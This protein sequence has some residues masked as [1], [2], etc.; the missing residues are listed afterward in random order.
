MC[1]LPA[2]KLDCE[3]ADPSSGTLNQDTLTSLQSPMVKDSLPGGC[4]THRHSSRLVKIQRL[5][6]E[7][8]L[9]HRSR[10]IFSVCPIWTLTKNRLSFLKRCYTGADLHHH[11]SQIKTRY[12]RQLHWS[13]VFKPARTG[14]FQSTG[15]TPCRMD[16]NKYLALL[17]LWAWYPF[18]LKLL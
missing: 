8:K 4:C 18:K 7:C 6:L 10:R 13:K 1:A 3:Q 9:V 5:R 15:F 17:R 2:G 14:F 12:I 11:T 16:T